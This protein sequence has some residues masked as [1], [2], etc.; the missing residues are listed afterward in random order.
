MVYGKPPFH[1]FKN[2]VHKMQAA[3]L[4]RQNYTSQLY[5]ARER[6]FPRGALSA[7]FPC[8]LLSIDACLEGLVSI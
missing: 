4:P 2:T 1:D 8:A 6:F 3:P 5:H 7:G